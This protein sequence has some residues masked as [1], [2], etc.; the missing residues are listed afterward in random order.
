MVDPSNLI[1]MTPGIT[2]SGM[3]GVILR[4]PQDIMTFSRAKWRTILLCRRCEAVITA[5][6]SSGNLVPPQAHDG[7]EFSCSPVSSDMLHQ[8]QIPS[9]L[10]MP[11]R[12]P[13]DALCFLDYSADIDPGPGVCFLRNPHSR[14]HAVLRAPASPEIGGGGCLQEAGV[15]PTKSDFAFTSDTGSDM[16]LPVS[17]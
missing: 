13:G 12:Q 2:E 11:G 4:K 5:N 3:I 16:L 14:I 1:M 15:R 17:L 6:G 10:D 9:G 8:P 7:P